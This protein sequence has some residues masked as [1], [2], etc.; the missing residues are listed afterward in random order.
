MKLM[1]KK[2]QGNLNG[3]KQNC[4]IYFIDLRTIFPATEKYGFK[5]LTG[6]GPGF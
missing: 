2:R 6:S 1:T 4:E 5:A 3:N